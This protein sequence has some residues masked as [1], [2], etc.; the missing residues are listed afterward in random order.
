[1]EPFQ[2]LFGVV[3]LVLDVTAQR[4]WTPPV[5]KPSLPV[6]QPKQESTVPPPAAPFDKCQVEEGEKIRCGPQDITAER[7]ANINCCFDGR[8][9]Y[10]GKAGTCDFKWFLVP[11]VHN[12]V[13]GI[14]L[15]SR[16]RNWSICL[17]AQ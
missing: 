7:C 11:F 2:Y 17:L 15:N 8:Q 12:V 14:N 4:Y 3:V 9:C 10:Y 1:M 13:V 6:Q 5:Q 16:N